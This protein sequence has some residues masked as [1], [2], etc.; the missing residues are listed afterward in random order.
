MIDTDEFYHALA[1]GLGILATAL[2]ILAVAVFYGYIPPSL[3][4]NL[5]ATELGTFSV[6]AIAGAG[7]SAYME[8]KRRR[9]R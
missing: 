3:V 9:S 8:G 7:G 5:T 2:A 6:L 4:G 1:V